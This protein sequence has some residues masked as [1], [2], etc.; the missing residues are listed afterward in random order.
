MSQKEGI[1]QG[2]GKLSKSKTGKI[3][4]LNLDQMKLTFG[5][6]TS[7]MVLKVRNS[8]STPTTFTHRTVENFVPSKK[9]GDDSASRNRGYCTAKDFGPREGTWRLDQ[10][11]GGNRTWVAIIA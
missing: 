5:A 7:S 2:A 9:E 11:I 10:P 6:L 3:R 4:K 8:N 1:L